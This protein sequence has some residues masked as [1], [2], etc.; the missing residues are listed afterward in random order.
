MDDPKKRQRAA[1]MRDHNFK[2]LLRGSTISMLGD[3]LTM[4][5]L[6]WLVLKLTGDTLALGFVIAL[7][8]IPRAVFILIGGALVDR[9]SPK[10]VLMLSK[11][12]SALLLGV[13]TVLVLN[14]QP[15]LT[16]SLSD[17][18]SL[19]IDMNA[20]LTLMLIYVLALGIGLAQ[21]FGIPSGTSIMPQAVGPEHLQAANG[22]LMGLRQL[23]MLL[24]PLLAAG[25]LAISSDGDGVVADAHGLAFAFGFDC[26]SF[27]VS[28]WTLSRVSL[29]T[30]P[31]RTE[32]P[33]SVLRSVGSGLTMVWNDVPLRLCF[34]YWGIVSLFIGGTMQVALPVLASEKLHGASAFG[35]L[36]GANGAGTL[37]GMAGAA[38]AGARL[39]F[40]SFGTVLLAGDAIAGLLVM[41]LGAVHAPWQACA[42]MLT[43]GLL[44]GYMQIKVF[45][46]IQRRVP[47]NMMGRAMS[48]F[49]FIF[50]GLAPLSAAVAGWALTLI[51]LSQ[52]FLGGG[53]IL[54]VFAALAYLFTP[55]GS[56]DT[57]NT[58]STPQPQ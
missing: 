46:W 35:L 23:S 33:Q 12:A 28:A 34:I 50:M 26:V 49:M 6:P 44:S 24:G 8:S 17:S 48:I 25:L 13:L 29:L 36:M 47:P 39:R 21:A 31:A 54:V 45:T 56:I 15:T 22:V 1:L 41:P 43:L 37:L 18:L 51:P 53:I 5:A 9:Y 38:V 3:Q 40:A 11:Y 7:M 19:T 27:L 30:A 55:I 14:N 20:H 52:M 2:W 58:A 4:V 42:L 16:L 32:A 57:D 10:R